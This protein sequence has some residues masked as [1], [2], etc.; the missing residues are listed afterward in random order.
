VTIKENRTSQE[1]EP[2]QRR[3]QDF[4]EN[5]TVRQVIHAAESG[6]DF[7]QAIDDELIVLVD[8]QKGEIGA[9]VS[10]LVGSIVV[11]ELWAAAQSRITMPEEERHPYYLYVDEV[12]NY[13]GEASSFATILSEAREYQLG[14]WCI[15]QYIERLDTGLRRALTNNARTKIVFDPTGSEEVSRLAGMLRG[16]DNPILRGLGDYRAVLQTPSE[17]EKREAVVVDTYPPW[18]TDRSDVAMV[19][20]AATNPTEP[21]TNDFQQSPPLGHGG[22][23]G[24]EHHAELLMQAKQHFEAEDGVQAQLLYQETGTEQPD[25]HIIH[26]NGDIAH[27]EAEAST[28]S[29]PAKVLA[30][31]RRAADAGNECIF[32]VEHGN[33]TKL[34]SIL[35]DPVDRR[36]DT[37]EDDHGTYD[38]YQ[39]DGD[40]VTDLDILHQAEYRIFEATETGLTEYTPSDTTEC[41]ELDDND[42]AELEAFCLYR[43][44]SGVCEALEQSC[45]LTHEP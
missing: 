15:T 43:D 40:P 2:I 11:T 10:Q 41:P 45:V 18:T 38:Y 34:D 29:K 42:R 12:Q 26:Q 17:E 35:S 3:L 36:G 25:G 19:K 33:A 13:A 27:L 21:A 37:H 16:V 14:C 44:E 22:N 24:G 9:S 20:A 1:L 8:V 28:L 31:L 6:V 5:R 39:V 23:A 7:R 32:I 30:N 4:V